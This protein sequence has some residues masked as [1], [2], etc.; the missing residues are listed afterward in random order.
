MKGLVECGMGLRKEARARI[1]WSFRV[2]KEMKIQWRET[3]FQNCLSF[4]SGI[5]EKQNGYAPYQKATGDWDSDRCGITGWDKNF[6]AIS[7][8]KRGLQSI[9]FRKRNVLKDIPRVKKKRFFSSPHWMMSLLRRGKLF[10]ITCNQFYSVE[11]SRY[12]M[13]L[14]TKNI[15]MKYVKEIINGRSGEEIS[16]LRLFHAAPE[17]LLYK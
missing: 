15:S 16:P 7:A 12:F 5:R 9:I 17:R 14:K 13:F 6:T 4:V 3:K 1:V 8:I 2:V 11:W 10:L